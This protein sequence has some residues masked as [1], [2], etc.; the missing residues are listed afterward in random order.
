MLALSRGAGE[1]SG[2]LLCKG[3]G[4]QSMGLG[5]VSPPSVPSAFLRPRPFIWFLQAAAV[6]GQARWG[7]KALPSPGTHKVSQTGRSS[8]SQLEMDRPP[9]WPSHSSSLRPGLPRRELGEGFGVT[10]LP[11][12]NSTPSLFVGVRVRLHLQLHKPKPGEGHHFSGSG[13]GLGQVGVQVGS[14]VGGGH[15]WGGRWKCRLGS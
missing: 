1:A 9:C 8:R 10:Q 11:P 5:P 7:R 3:G 15:G 4:V 13:W 14:R 2:P 6:G 12:A